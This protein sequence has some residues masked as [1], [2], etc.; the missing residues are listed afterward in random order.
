[1][2]ARRR[3]IA[4]WVACHILPHEEE[5]RRWL[6][7]SVSEPADVN[8]IIQQAYCRL[9]ELDYTGHIQNARGYFYATVRSVFLER[10]RR[11]RIVQIQAMADLDM[12]AIADETPSPE[13]VT[14]ARL[15]LR[16]VM[17]VLNS[18]PPAYRDALKLRRIEGLSQKETAR[19]L[20]V[21]EKMIENNTVRGLKMLLSALVE[22][23]ANGAARH[24][25]TE[26]E[27]QHAYARY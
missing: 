15:E 12:L 3:E 16:S 10:I 21:T 24:V 13:V 26:D 2:D 20:G 6:L 22:T 23:R 7:R 18:L 9:A 14:G 1:M 17:D 11:E 5:V 4:R 27:L 25:N 19:R 8:D